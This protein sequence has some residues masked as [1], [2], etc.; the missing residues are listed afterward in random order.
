MDPLKRKPLQGT[1]NIIRFN[2]HFYVL[3]FLVSVLLSTLNEIAF[4][5]SPLLI[6]LQILL[7]SVTLISLIVSCYVYDRSGLYSF[8]WLTIDR[9]PGKQIININ[10]GFDE[11]SWILQDQFPNSQLTVMDFYDPVRHTEVSIKRARKAYSVY[12]GT[13]K[14]ST[15]SK[16]IETD[17]ADYIFLVFAAHE[18]RNNEERTNFFRSLEAVLKPGGQ[19]VIVEHQRD[20]ANFLAYNMGFLHF[21]SKKTWLKTFEDSG[22]SHIAELQVNPFVSSFIITK[23]GTA[24]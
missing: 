19:L 4:D 17:K 21:L 16:V 14:I 13:I 5:R 20:M 15:T 8:N 2:W 6:V 23:N 9:T 10:A 18:I 3:I 1:W 22:L 24:A 12:P 11:T 7:I